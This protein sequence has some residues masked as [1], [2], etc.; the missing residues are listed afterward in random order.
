[1]FTSEIT[2]EF[3]PLP[4]ETEEEYWATMRY[5]AEVMFSDLTAPVAELE[6]VSE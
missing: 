3:V 2:M 1:M 5:F 4:T 6:A